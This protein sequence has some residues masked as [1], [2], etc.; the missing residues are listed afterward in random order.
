MPANLA[1]ALQI[2]L[3]SVKVLDRYIGVTVAKAYL[4]VMLILVSLFSFLTLVEE[5]DEVGEGRYQALDALMF[6]GL[7]LPHRMMD[8]L[9]VTALL[10]SVI[11]LGWLAGS[12]EL[13]VMR[14]AGVSVLRIG[15]G[16]IKAGAVLMLLGIILAELVVPPLA[17]TAQLERSLALTGSIALTS[18]QGFWARD[19]RRFVNIRHVLA[20]GVL[21]GVDIYEFDEAGQLRRFIQARQAMI[22]DERQWLLVDVDRKLNNGHQIV[23][24]HLDRLSWKSFLSTDL[25]K[26]LVLPPESLAPSDLRRVIHDLRE[27]DQSTYR[28][29]L[30]FW[31]KLGIPLSTGV[32]ILLSIPFVFG[33]MRDA[34]AGYR[35]ALGSVVGVAFYMANQIVGH[36]GLLLSLNPI[37]VVMTPMLVMLVF[38]VLAFR[39]VR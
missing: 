13:L 33:S 9:P 17:R 21:A 8:V 35:I 36:L 7:T 38:A 24:Q 22:V 26:L 3:H 29:E 25:L 34:T 5:L 10:G 27:R 18:E 2:S 12:N 4:L 28:Y 30:V 15:W 14:A 16:V 23:T 39:R 37:L 20:D 19:N 11:G 1:T 31:Q 32:M 6:T